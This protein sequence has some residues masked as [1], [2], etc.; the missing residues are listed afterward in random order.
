MK[1]HSDQNKSTS[2]RANANKPFFSGK[3]GN[4]NSFF[5]PN[6]RNLQ[7]SPF[8]TVQT[9]PEKVEE[10]NKEESINEEK[11][12]E[13]QNGLKT[14]NPGDPPINPDTPVGHIQY[15]I[16]KTHYGTFYLIQRHFKDDGKSIASFSEFS[17]E[18]SKRE[19]QFGKVEPVIRH[20][21]VFKKPKHQSFYDYSEIYTYPLTEEEKILENQRLGK[22]SVELELD[23][24]FGKKETGNQVV[25]PESPVSTQ[26]SEQK[27]AVGDAKGNTE[28]EKAT[29]AG[30]QG[31]SAGPYWKHEWHVDR[32]GR[33][34]LF[35][36]EVGGKRHHTKPGPGYA[37]IRKMASLFPGDVG[38]DTRFEKFK[39]HPQ[40]SEGQNPELN[41]WMKKTP[42]W[43]NPDHFD[44]GTA[45]FEDLAEFKDVSHNKKGTGFYYMGYIFDPFIYEKLEEEKSDKENKKYIGTVANYRGYV[46]AENGIILHDTP[47]PSDEAYQAKRDNAGE[48]VIDHNHPLTVV[49]EGN[50]DNEGW[51]LVKTPI[52]EVGWIERRYI[53][54]K[55]EIKSQE[56]FPSYTVQEGDNLESLINSY[57]EDY[58]YATG[59]DRR[60]VALAIYLYN[61]DK[62]GSGVYRNVD[63]YKN[64]G[65]WKDSLDPWMQETRANYESVELYTGGKVLLPP[66]EFI[67]E[68]RKLGE[69]EKRPDFVNAVIEGGRVI[70]GFIA[71]VGIGFWDALSG[72]VED[73]YNLVVD[74]FTGEIFNQIAEMF[75]T[76]MDL[77]LEGVWDMIKDFGTSTWEEVVAAWNNPNPYERGKYFGEIIGMILFEVV[78]A[79]LTWGVGTAI[80]N[81]TRVTKIMKLFPSWTKKIDKPKYKNKYDNIDKPKDRDIDLDKDKNK[82]D[83]DKDKNDKESDKDKAE[84]T[85]AALKAKVYVE[86]Q[87]A[88]NPSPEV[89]LVL[90]F[91][92]KTPGMKLSG[93]KRYKAER[94]SKGEGHFRIYYNPTLD[95]DYS[96]GEN[97]GTVERNKLEDHEFKQAQEIVDF[98]GGEFKGQK[99]KDMPGIDGHL[100]GKPVS[101]K[102]YTGESPAGV[103]KHASKAEDQILKA[104]L[105]DVDVYVNAKK[106]NSDQMIDFIKNGP[107]KDIPNQGLVDKIY[108][109]VSDGWIE[110][111]AENI[112]KL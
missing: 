25:T 91:I 50:D 12:T 68:M 47:S 6:G 36:W 69:I 7:R 23:P 48:Y 9:K 46:N 45:D 75:N 40:A 27:I 80:K 76:I 60:T 33:E 15:E 52:G 64:A 102:E 55:P 57:Y 70:Q 100:D 13:N 93:G 84:D 32:F 95:N 10:I 92:N 29:E 35:V 14:A 89:R 101:L 53:S 83:H 51:V 54:K 43:D 98:K 21:R 103:L 106:L 42:G 63:K 49:A 79:I 26:Q 56:I 108:I 88:L 59:N 78:L 109:Q 5:T 4:E 65:S 67:Q 96:E 3:D 74:I 39:H 82:S 19:V 34:A 85:Q 71:G 86:S 112:I 99:V 87:D 107:L 104:G 41:W 111:G 44:N 11:N 20:N 37:Y 62:P 38:Y 28:E 77:G 31:Q 24:N 72:A 16:R 30:E 73:L 81:S 2:S 94:N 22:T 1:T 105:K 17:T 8:F 61:K 90:S 97:N 66:V 110:I 58:P 18:K